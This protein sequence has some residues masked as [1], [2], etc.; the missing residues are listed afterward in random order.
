[1]D[2]LDHDVVGLGGQ[3]GTKHA[4]VLL[5]GGSI[6]S[7]TIER[8]QRRQR[9]E[10]GKER[11]GNIHEHIAKDE[12]W[13]SPARAFLGGHPTRGGRQSRRIKILGVPRKRNFRK[14]PDAQI[15]QLDSD[16]YIERLLP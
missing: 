16:Q 3:Q 12:P 13:L 8:D 5:H 14:K 9:G 7:Q 11:E 10:D 15:G 6:R 1:M 4:E 2:L